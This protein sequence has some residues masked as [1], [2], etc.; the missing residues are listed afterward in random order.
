ML[1]SVEDLDVRVF[2][3]P[4]CQAVGAHMPD[5]VADGCVIVVVRG[6]SAR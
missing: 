2:S 5:V 6:I 4:N 3:L 1:T